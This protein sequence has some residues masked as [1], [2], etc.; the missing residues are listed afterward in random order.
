MTAR[1]R[2]RF[3]C[4]HCPVYSQRRHAR[5]GHQWQCKA[6][7]THRW[8]EYHHCSRIGVP[9][10][11]AHDTLGTLRIGAQ[12]LS[13][14][15]GA[16]ATN[17]TAGITFGTT[18]LS[19]NATFDAVNSGSAN[20]QLT[21]GAVGEPEQACS[22]TKTGNGTLRLN[23]AGSYSGGTMLSQGAITLGIDNALG[24]GGF[25]FA[26][27]TLNANNSTD[28][29]IGALTLTADS[30]L[31]LSPGGA[32]AILYFRRGL[33]RCQRHPYHHRLVWLSRRIRLERQNRLL[34]GDDAQR[35]ISATYPF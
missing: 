24:S 10:G 18:T 26:A 34:R 28:S 13:V 17:G 27:G 31:N 4:L 29:T 5:P 14:T 23:G 30:T 2:Q 20:A 16:N 15:A 1:Q 3:G 32:A 8:W 35:R 22:L 25:N 21:L 9:P 12:T 7:T 6:P 19:G 33:C 11:A